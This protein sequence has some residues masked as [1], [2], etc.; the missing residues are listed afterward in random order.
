MQ[1][2]IL[3][4]IAIAHDYFNQGGGAD[5]V[6]AEMYAMI[7]GAKLITTVA[8]PDKMPEKLRGVHVQT[9]WMQA[10]P[11]MRKLYRFY[12]I[13]YPLAIETLDCKRFD[14]IL[15]SSSGYAKG[16]KKRRDA[17]HICYCHNPMR[18]VWEYDRYVAHESFNYMAKAVIS[19][20]VKMLK[21]WDIY[22]AKRPDHYITNSL[23]S[24]DRIFRAYGRV[25]TVIPPPIEVGNFSISQSTD[26]Y[27]LILARLVSYRRIDTA[28]E[29]C[30][31]NERKLIII[32]SGPDLT[33]LARLAGSN[34]QFMGNLSD[35]EV[36]RYV[37]RCRA[38]LFTGVEDF[39]MVVLEA[40]ASGRPTIAYRGG[41][42]LET[43]IDGQTGLF[44][45]D[46]TSESLSQA[47]YRF[48]EQEWYPSAIRAHAM[49]FSPEIFRERF[50]TF[51]QSLGLA[52]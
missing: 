1:V 52:M 11:Y 16:I 35:G 41:G 20:S 51:L 5:K 25:C 47:M 46:Q 2:I 15:S 22:A 29:A 30:T 3:M 32:G 6:A 7:P 8:L 12:F 14:L 10:L 27:Y 44:Y 43:I 42:A 28:I 48:E 45:D 4:N 21:L 40:A 33:R 34:V 38:L 9:S 36:A 17:L 13:L 49:K 26:D 23:Y 37:S 19:L 50:L 18:W 24:A 31:K 39:G